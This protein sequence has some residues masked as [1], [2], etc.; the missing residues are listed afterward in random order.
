M[1]DKPIGSCDDL[2]LPNCGGGGD[3]LA[4]IVSTVFIVI[5][6]LATLYLIVAGIQY[7]ASGG[8]PNKTRQAKDSI[9]YALIGVVLSFSI[10][11][12]IEFVFLR[13]NTGLGL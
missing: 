12:I 1:N 6:A 11:A 4:D 3:G 13:S 5:G 7:A 8:D 10:F 9:I 2:G